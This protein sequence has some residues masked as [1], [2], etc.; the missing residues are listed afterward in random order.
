MTLE[1]AINDLDAAASELNTSRKV[2]DHLKECTK[3]IRESIKLKEESP[4][5]GQ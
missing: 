4:A 5:L 1:Q 2:H 3:L